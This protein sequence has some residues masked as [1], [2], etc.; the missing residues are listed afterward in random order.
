MA[1][2]PDLLP[3]QQKRYRQGHQHQC[4]TS[5]QRRGP[6][7]THP[8][9]HVGCEKREYGAETG[10]EEGVGGDSGGREHQVGVDDI[11]EQGKEDAED[12]E[13]RE[14]AGE[15]GHDPVDF[16]AFEPGPAE[17][18]EAACE[19]DSAGDGDGEAP[20]GDRDVVVCGEFAHVAAVG[21][22]DDDESD[23]FARDHAEV[24][25]AADAL[26]EA[27]L[28]LKDEGVG[29]KEEV[30]EA[31]DEGHIERD[32][33]DDGFGEKN[34]DRARDVLCEEFLDVDFD[35]FL[36]GVDAPVFGTA[37]EFLR[38]VYKDDGRVGFGEKEQDKSEGDEAHDG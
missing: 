6:L 24:G 28:A 2:P 16:V 8:V 29:G 31:V 4:H 13:A 36:L 10:A 26:V 15:R 27:V 22:G 14:E 37:T 35:F 7:D 9:E 32:E 18:E 1:L 25:E 33:Q 23:D 11:V 12:T 34:P 17:P 5:Q 30:E 3:I 38:F 20:F 21:A 19:G